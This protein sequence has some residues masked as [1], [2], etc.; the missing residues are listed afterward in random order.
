MVGINIKTYFPTSSWNAATR[1]R[2]WF[3]SHWMELLEC[4][5]SCKLP[6]TYRI[7]HQLKHRW[8]ENWKFGGMFSLRK[9]V[10]LENPWI[11]LCQSEYMHHLFELFLLAPFFEREKR[12]TDCNV[13]RAF[14][15]FSSNTIKGAGLLDSSDF[16]F[17]KYDKARA[18]W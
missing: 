8:T 2:T 9:G 6:H 11:F 13:K 5:K 18:K 1:N 14:I 15:S 7:K 17:W 4:L 12:K 16:Q 3:A 10:F